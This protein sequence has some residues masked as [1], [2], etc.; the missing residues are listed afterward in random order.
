MQHHSW[1]QVEFN[2]H[3]CTVECEW[4]DKSKHWLM[5]RPTDEPGG[6]YVVNEE[7]ITD[8]AVIA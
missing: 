2:G 5:L 6:V 3:T 1:D 7:Q 4:D 8:D